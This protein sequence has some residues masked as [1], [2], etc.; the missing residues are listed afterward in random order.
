[1]PYERTVRIRV[2]AAHNGHGGT[3]RS[4]D[5]LRPRGSASVDRAMWAWTAGRGFRITLL[6]FGTHPQRHPVI[7]SQS[8]ARMID[9]VRPEAASQICGH[10]A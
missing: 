8:C 6:G 7:Q 2:P 9:F 5:Q 1:M 4:R 3:A 10:T